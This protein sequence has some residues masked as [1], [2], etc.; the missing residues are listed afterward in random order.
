MS[1]NTGDLSTWLEVAEELRRIYEGNIHRIDD[2]LGRDGCEIKLEVM[3]TRV[4]DLEE[5][6]ALL[7][8]TVEE[9]EKTALNCSDHAAETERDNI[10][11][12]HAQEK[13]EADLRRAMQDTNKL[14]DELEKSKTE[15]AELSNKLSDMKEVQLTMNW[16][17]IRMCSV[18]PHQTVNKQDTYTSCSVVHGNQLLIQELITVLSNGDNKLHRHIKH[19][20]VMLK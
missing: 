18:A 3:K 17:N 8:Q 4:S 15:A 19:G 7:V 20:P 10:N 14:Q 12:R 9:C 6:S 1:A 13:S 11:L 2:E 5:Q 16:T